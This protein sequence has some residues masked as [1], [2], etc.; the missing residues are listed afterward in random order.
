[1]STNP[2]EKLDLQYPVFDRRFD[3]TRDELTNLEVIGRIVKLVNDIIDI[4]NN[5]NSNLDRY[6]LSDNITVNRKLSPNGNFT[7]SLMGR[8]VSVVLAQID[9]NGVKIADNRDKIAYLL[10]QFSDGQTGWVIDGGFF[11][12]TG[13]KQNYD[14]GMFYHGRRY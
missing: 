4:I 6:E 1:M 2:L 10:S 13:I 14:G 11:E 7:G 12:D 8:L 9:D 5:W 3:F